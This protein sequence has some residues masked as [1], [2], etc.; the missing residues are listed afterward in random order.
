M[1]AGTELLKFKNAEDI[2]DNFCQS[3]RIFQD[4]RL[5]KEHLSR[6]EQHFVVRKWIDIDVDMEFRGFVSNGKLNALSQYN[7]LAFFP[8]LLEM[9]DSIAQRIVTFWEEKIKSKLEKKY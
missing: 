3:E 7:H 2:L 4:M 6:F 1:E 8:R 5:A 9:K